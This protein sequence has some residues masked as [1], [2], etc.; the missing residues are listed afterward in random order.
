MGRTRVAFLRQWTFRTKSDHDALFVEVRLSHGRKQ[1]RKAALLRLCTANLGGRFDEANLRNLLNLQPDILACQ[2][3]S[4]QR[5]ITLVC[6]EYGYRRL[7]G[8]GGGQVGQAAT[9]TF[10]GPRITERRPGTWIK[11]LGAVSIGKGAGP[12]V[13]KPKWWLKTRLSVDGIRFSA[14]SW[15]ATASQQ[16]KGRWLAAFKETRIWVGIAATLSRPVFTLGDTN[17]DFQQ[18][19]TRWILKHGMT[20]NHE[21]LGEVATHGRRSIDAVCV[22]RALVR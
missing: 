4:D 3:A 13:A 8:E 7:D 22:Q 6:E 10:A 15:H 14:S 16:F 19:L 2:E 11:L 17:S 12:D 18:P 1:K 21:Q 5:W 20:S 9:P